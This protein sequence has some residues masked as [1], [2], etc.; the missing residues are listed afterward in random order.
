MFLL[1]VD[2]GTRPPVKPRG[3]DSSEMSSGL[4]GLNKS[5]DCDLSRS[6]SGSEL[7]DPLG[8]FYVLTTLLRKLSL[9]V[10]WDGNEEKWV[11]GSCIARVCYCFHI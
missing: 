5:E 7:I 3:T 1:L 10:V 6:T 2:T 11:K 4:N 9:Y 8:M